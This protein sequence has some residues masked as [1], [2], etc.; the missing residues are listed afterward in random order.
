MRENNYFQKIKNPTIRY[1]RFSLVLFIIYL[2]TRIA[3]KLPHSP[4]AFGKIFLSRTTE[5]ISIS[6]GF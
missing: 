2:H 6:T 3:R 4:Y 5:L 1:L